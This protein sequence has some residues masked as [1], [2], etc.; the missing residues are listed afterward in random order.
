MSR[1]YTERMREGKGDAVPPKEPK[2][3]KRLPDRR[4][5][6]EGRS[7]DDEEDSGFD[8]AKDTESYSVEEGVELNDEQKA[9]IQSYSLTWEVRS[10]CTLPLPHS[11][12]PSPR[13]P[14]VGSHALEGRLPHRLRLPSQ[15]DRRQERLL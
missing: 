4:A 10:I 12:H 2:K 1:P 3:A 6:Q 9:A 15:H 5:E 11:D 7:V 14:P 13:T 8:P